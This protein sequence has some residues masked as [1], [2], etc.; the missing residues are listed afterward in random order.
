MS[1]ADTANAITIAVWVLAAI[2]L[3]RW[4][5]ARGKSQGLSAGQKA[6]E[7]GR[8]VAAAFSPKDRG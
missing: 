6:A 4:A 1:G 3:L 2:G 7:V 5:H 8:E